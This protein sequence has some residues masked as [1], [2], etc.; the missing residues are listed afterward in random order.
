ML[1]QAR[2]IFLVLLLAALA[3]PAASAEAIQ[4]G[5][6]AR[7]AYVD[8]RAN[9]LQKAIRVDDV[10]R[11]TYL[12]DRATP[13][14]NALESVGDYWHEE[15]P[16]G[17]TVVAGGFLFRT[18]PDNV[19]FLVEIVNDHTSGRDNY[20]L[21]SYN[22]LPLW[23]GAFVEHI[24]WQLDDDTATA[25]DT[26][27]LP[28]LPP[29]LGAWQS[30]FGLTLEG[31]GAERFFVRA[32]V[33]EVWLC[34]DEMPCPVMGAGPSMAADLGPSG[35]WFFEDGS[36]TRQT[37]LDP[38]DLLHWRSGVLAGFADGVGLWFHD[39]FDGWTL[40]AGLQPEQMIVWRGSAVV[41]FGA[42]GLWLHD[43]TRWTGLTSADAVSL[44]SLGEELAAS[45]GGDLGTWIY[46]GSDWTLAT[47]ATA[48]KLQRLR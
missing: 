26:A 36:W 31:T 32:H 24:A 5:F 28:A 4:I 42:N 29:E 22:N 20:L 9:A 3:Q 35:L 15:P 21:R 27:D 12:Y 41:D 1:D 8:D 37:T 38:I 25:I 30:V 48:E 46:D 47:P 34:S 40:L 10:I 44:A 17:I 39:L 19:R 33:E 18:D 11:G 23:N 6:K 16:F 7:V 14:S 2:P 13:D 45:F 43:G